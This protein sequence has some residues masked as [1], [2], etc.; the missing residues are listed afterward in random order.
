VTKII[1]RN[2]KFFEKPADPRLVKRAWKLMFAVM[3]SFIMFM[4]W[5]VSRFEELP[6]AISNSLI[7]AAIISFPIAMTLSFR[8]MLP[9]PP[10]LPRSARWVTYYRSRLKVHLA[11]FAILLAVTC[12]IVLEAPDAVPTLTA[13]LCLASVYY[14]VALPV[15]YCKARNR[16]RA[17]TVLQF[18]GSPIHWRFETA[19]WQQWISS[20]LESREGISERA[21]KRLRKK[22]SR[23]P[24]EVYFGER[25]Y[26][27]GGVY[28]VWNE[29]ACTLKNAL[30]ETASPARL[31]F[32]FRKLKV[33][34]KS[35]S[36]SGEVQTVP[37][38]AGRES[39]IVRLQEKLSEWAPTAEVR[40]T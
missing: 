27:C 4:Y 18:T 17:I 29:S 6:P 12:L 3:A 5:V 8:V 15:I 22:F 2:V 33:E 40:L 35:W 11:V 37:I 10:Q 23:A 14:L 30:L 9:K 39:D 16:D 7:A 26:C 31:L 38:P 24:A 1:W 13:G 19:L 20:E 25:G 34:A 21:K 32:V 28:T 36:F